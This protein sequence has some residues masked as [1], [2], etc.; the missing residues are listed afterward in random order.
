MVSQIV[1]TLLS[2]AVEQGCQPA[3]VHL[4]GQNAAGASSLPSSGL[5]IPTKRF[6]NEPFGLLGVILV[7]MVREKM[8]MKKN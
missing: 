2:K 6:P 4:H 3:P 5:P 7:M 1:L 8:M